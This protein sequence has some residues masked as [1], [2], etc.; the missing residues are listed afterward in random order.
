MVLGF[1]F[2]P[3][4]GVGVGGG[5]KSLGQNFSFS[6]KTFTQRAKTEW[7]K[8]RETDSG[9][10]REENKG[11]LSELLNW[12]H[13]SETRVGEFPCFCHLL[14]SL[15]AP[16]WLTFPVFSCA[17]I[18]CRQRVRPCLPIL[19]FQL[20]GGFLWGFFLFEDNMLRCKH[21]PLTSFSSSLLLH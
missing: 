15:R 17:D 14:P 18:R 6:K 12:H 9:R 7:E 2:F 11:T 4:V 1:V 5:E 3:G 20:V 10:G 19:C 21:L 13:Q 8:K 16:K